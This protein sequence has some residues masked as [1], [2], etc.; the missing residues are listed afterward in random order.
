MACF[1]GLISTSLISSCFIL[2]FA[3]LSPVL[4]LTQVWEKS[5]L[6]QK[7]FRNI[8]A[9]NWQVLGILQK[10]MNQAYINTLQKGIKSYSVYHIIEVEINI[11]VVSKVIFLQ[12]WNQPAC[13]QS[14][15]SY[16]SHWTCAS[17]CL[18]LDVANLSVSF[19][20]EST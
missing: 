11:M 9:K 18:M 8:S 3:E 4:T 19:A 6:N 5:L 14:S 16:Y 1:L 10:P 13:L 17:C 15:D 12:L 20:W 2:F 7:E